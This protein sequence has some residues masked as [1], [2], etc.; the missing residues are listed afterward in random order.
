[1]EQPDNGVSR[2]SKYFAAG[3]IKPLPVL[4]EEKELPN[5]SPDGAGEPHT[6]GSHKPRARKRNASEVSGLSSSSS[7]NKKTSRPYAPPETYARLTCLPDYLKEN[8]D[9]K[10]ESHS[11]GSILTGYLS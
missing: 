8:L 5:L 1:M 10:L 3:R 9:G 2:K 4:D 7:K 11:R 6:S